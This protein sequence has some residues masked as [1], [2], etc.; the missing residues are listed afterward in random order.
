[1]RLL[2]Q[3]LTGCTFTSTISDSSAATYRSSGSIAYISEDD[4]TCGASDATDY[5]RTYIDTCTI[6]RERVFW[7][8]L[9]AESIVIS[10]GFE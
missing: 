10:L 9:T 6:I 2:Q 4:S 5:H 8:E 7:N 1:M 3:S